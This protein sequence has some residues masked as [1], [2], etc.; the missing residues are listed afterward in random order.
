MRESINNT[1][2]G[3]FHDLQ[4]VAELVDILQVISVIC[5]LAADENVVVVYDFVVGQS[6]VVVLVGRRKQMVYFISGHL[7]A[8]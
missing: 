4:F 8:K 2:R 7:T 3:N 1:F 6:V 5:G